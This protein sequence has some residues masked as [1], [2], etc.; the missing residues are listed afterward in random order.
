MEDR[1]RADA[2]VFSANVA[3]HRKSKGERERERERERGRREYFRELIILSS[4]IMYPQCFCWQKDNPDE[5]SIPAGCSC[6]RTP[7]T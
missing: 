7:T 5:G 2:D 4:H 3:K 6:Q 1:G